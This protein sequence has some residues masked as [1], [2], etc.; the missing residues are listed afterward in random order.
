MKDP[1]D[2]MT[3]A[4]ATNTPRRLPLSS[5]LPQTRLPRESESMIAKHRGTVCEP[6]ETRSS[7][8]SYVHI[9]THVVRAQFYLSDIPP[10]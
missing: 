4:G 9:H 2:V 3:A 10:E 8:A 5:A 6:R 1:R 7:M